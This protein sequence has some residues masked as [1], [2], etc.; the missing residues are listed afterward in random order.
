V[1]RKEEEEYLLERSKQF[2]ETAE[3]QITRGL[4][5]LAVFSLEQALQLFLKSKML[6]GGADFPRTHSIRALLETLSD[7]AP[8][9]KKPAVTSVLNNYLLEL[10]MLEDAYVTSRYVP[11]EFKK[12]EAERLMKVAREVMKNVT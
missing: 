9:E 4:H 5:G 6:A 8:E 3:Y 2:L 1:T 10:G 12:E 11:R 7:L